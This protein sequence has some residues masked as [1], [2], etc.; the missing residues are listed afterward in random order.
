MHISATA[1]VTLA[2]AGQALSRAAD[3]VCTAASASTLLWRVTDFEYH[4]ARYAMPGS[5]MAYGLTNFTLRNSALAHTA[6][7]TALSTRQPDFFA[8]DAVYDCAT[9]PEDAFDLSR[10]T[11]DRRAGLLSIN[12]T[13]VCDRDGS[14]F[15]GVGHV[16]IRLT[17][18]QKHQE[19]STSSGKISETT[20]A[21]DKVDVPVNITYLQ[22]V[23]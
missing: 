12:Q 15:D 13:W 4:E 22:G 7:C 8:G 21:C 20:V 23:A 3:M 11:F 17:C 6:R 14:R 2:L 10:F 1:A 9:R 5:E 19:S 18:D 16:K